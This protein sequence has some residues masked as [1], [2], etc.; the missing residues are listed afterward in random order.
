[1]A[2]EFQRFVHDTVYVDHVDLADLE[3]Y[4]EHIRKR[5]HHYLEQEL[6]GALY[7]DGVTNPTYIHL[8]TYHYS[9]T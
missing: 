2:Q 1:M 8:D 9:R 5:P 3:T 6:W 7:I 4:L